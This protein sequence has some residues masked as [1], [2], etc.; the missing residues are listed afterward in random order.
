MS[1]PFALPYRLDTAASF[2]PLVRDNRFT[3]I[4]RLSVEFEHWVYLPALQRAVARLRPR[5]PG[6][7][8]G[9]RKGFFWGYLEPLV[10]DIPI[11]PEEPYPCMIPHQRELRDGLVRVTA[12]QN[13]V[14]V[15]FSHVVTDGTGAMTF[16]SALT[17]AYLEELGT[18][19]ERTIEPVA[20]TAEEWENAF[21]RYAPT[22][23][24]AQSITRL[25]YQPKTRLLPR[26]HY[27]VIHGMVQTSDL[28][29]Q[30]ARL[31]LKIGEY[32]VAL[33]MAAIQDLLWGNDH[34]GDASPDLNNSVDLSGIDR[35]RARAG[36]IRILV[37]VD[38]RRFFPSKTLR[39]FFSFVA[40]EIDPRLGYRDFPEIAQ[41]VRW[42]MRG[43][44]I[45][46]RLMA[47][48]SRDVQMH[49]TMLIRAIPS[50][51]KE[52]VMTWIYPIAG[53]ARFSASLSNLGAITL[54]APFASRVRR[55]AFIPPPS[56][57]TR[58]NCSVISWKEETVITFGSTDCA[59]ALERAFF[60]RLR[61]DGINA[62]I[63]EGTS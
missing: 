56:P 7:Y 15:E 39:N 20:T 4:F 33:L 61:D 63:S 14:G 5:F 3:S 45:P 28:K 52:Q 1:Q 36:L 10:G 58:T 50:L 41:E 21:L 37:P 13:R 19:T 35:N 29:A 53:E 25:A 42:Q 38:L 60:L 49:Q 57:W 17:C 43:A 27:R 62:L 22:P 16:L 26:G 44:L 9:L 30:A 34:R 8:V 51:I 2:W 46:R 47:H 40:P 48:L 31:D 6:F 11:V 59:R 12:W 18:V 55:F 54:P 23:L 24:P 32:L